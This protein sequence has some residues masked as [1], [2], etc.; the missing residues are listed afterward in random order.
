MTLT[1]KK[2]LVAILTVF[3]LFSASMFM[4]NVVKATDDTNDMTFEMV[5]GASLRLDAENNGIRYSANVGAGV[6]D[7][8][9]N[10]EG[11]YFGMLVVPES[12]L[13]YVEEGANVVAELIKDIPSAYLWNLTNME[14]FEGKLN[15]V[16]SNVLYE[17][18][19]VK[20]L[21]I[22][23]Y[24]D[25]ADYIVAEGYTETLRSVGEVVDSSLLDFDRFMKDPYTENS[26]KV[27]Y[28]FNY[29]ADSQNAGIDEES[30]RANVENFVEACVT[31]E[32]DYKV[33]SFAGETDYSMY[34]ENTTVNSTVDGNYNFY[35]K[36]A[37]LSVSGNNLLCTPYSASLSTGYGGVAITF[38]RP[39]K[40]TESTTLS[41]NV[42]LQGLSALHL[43]VLGSPS[44]LY[45]ATYTN[46]AW[47]NIKVK[48]TDIGYAIGTNMNGL[49]IFYV[50][51]LV[52]TQDFKLESVKL[53][54]E[55]VL[56]ENEL[57]NFD[58]E[59]VDYSENYSNITVSSSSNATLNACK[60]V[61]LTHS[62]YGQDG[63]FGPEKEG[64]G[65][66]SVVSN[67][68]Y[69]LG[70]AIKFNE[71]KVA[72]EG[73]QIKIRYYRTSKNNPNDGIFYFASYGSTTHDGGSS[74][75]GYWDK[76]ETLT[77]NI[78]DFGYKAGD[79]VEGIQIFVVKG[80]SLYIDYITVVA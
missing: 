52:L 35:S 56:A 67:N 27:L 69:G 8:V 23:Y 11:A 20:R 80:A 43:G 61:I 31:N 45:E 50:A 1:L 29:L 21:A 17:N 57:I 32:A 15:G 12:Y 25:G 60:N 49:Q 39:I 37:T 44:S 79:T 6:V 77:I 4:T 54:Y 3:M 59:H 70:V 66:V 26:R 38:V 62:I 48:A 51:N 2:I 24:F 74:G 65:V 41:I 16:V 33:I 64:N 72:T 78:S 30:A 73:M 71:K 7:I 14:V 40:V 5:A 76:W 19:N 34:Y 28:E 68:N 13:S 10:T 58:G 42:R 18:F 47:N 53:V 36:N 46:N 55:P 75:A 9:E 22:A 63:Y